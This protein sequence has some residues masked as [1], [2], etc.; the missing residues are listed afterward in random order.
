MNKAKAIKEKRMRASDTPQI[1]LLAGTDGLGGYI[2]PALDDHGGTAWLAY[3]NVVEA[4]AAAQFQK[5]MYDIDC[6]PVRIL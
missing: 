3:P 2:G 4:R 1:W 5:E 6:Q